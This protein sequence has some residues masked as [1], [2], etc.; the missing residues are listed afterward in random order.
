[1]ERIPKQGEFYRHFK[2]KLYQITALAEHS[3][4]GEQFVVY[5]ALYGDFKTYIRPLSMFVS[6]VDHVKYPDVTQ[7]YRFEQVTLCAE[8]TDE[9]N[10]K[11]SAAFT[12]PNE[13]EPSANPYL[14]AFIEA[15][16]FKER[17][18]ALSRMKGKVGQAE[19]DSVYLIMDMQQGNG[20]LDQQLAGIR[21]HLEI[22]NRYDGSRLR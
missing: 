20:D 10:E 21:K 15:E 7:R 19:L 2:N 3:E 6:E 22:R 5:Q 18:D 1:M 9:E 14:M 11:I 8:F 12:E 13:E 17:L 4:T 16:N